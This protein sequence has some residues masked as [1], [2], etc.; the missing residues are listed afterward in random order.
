MVYMTLLYI[1]GSQ[2]VATSESPGNL[3]KWAFI[4]GHSEP[5]VWGGEQGWY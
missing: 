2:I 3:C 1:F 5:Q 4:P